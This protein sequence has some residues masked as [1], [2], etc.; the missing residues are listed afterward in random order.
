MITCYKCNSSGVLFATRKLNKA[1]Y[2]FLCN[3]C[4]IWKLKGYSNKIPK[5]NDKLSPDRTN[6]NRLEDSTSSETMTEQERNEFLKEFETRT[7]KI[8]FEDGLDY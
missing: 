7:P 3:N 5:W 2:C 6:S 8:E 4:D 1:L